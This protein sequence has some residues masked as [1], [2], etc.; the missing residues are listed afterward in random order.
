MTI[1]RPDKSEEEIRTF[2][3]DG[4]FM[5]TMELTSE[6]PPGI[7]Q[8]FAEIEGSQIHVFTF[9]VK[10]E[11]LAIVPKWVKNNADWWAQDLITDDD[12]VKGIQ[13]LVEQGIII[14]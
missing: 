5:T 9:N 13:Y 8:V 6:S 4:N 10:V 1:I 2:S 12:F 11:D 7:Y 3:R 14:V